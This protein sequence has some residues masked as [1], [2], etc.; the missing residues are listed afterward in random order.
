MDKSRCKTLADQIVFI[1]WQLG[2]SRIPYYRATP[3]QITF[4]LYREF[5]VS[6]DM[7]ITSTCREDPRI[8]QDGHFVQDGIEHPVWALFDYS[9]ENLWLTDSDKG[10]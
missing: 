10:S 7:R 4:R 6:A 8:G 2:T 9:G 5:G 1:L 3:G